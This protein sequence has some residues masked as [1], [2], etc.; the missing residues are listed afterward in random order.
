MK[1][2]QFI[3]QADYEKAVL[4]NIERSKAIEELNKLILAKMT[5]VTMQRGDTFV[6]I[7]EG[8]EFDV[9]GYVFKVPEPCDHIVSA[10]YDDHVKERRQVFKIIEGY[11]N[12]CGDEVE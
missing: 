2:P 12:R 3:T 4:Q 7:K 9:M 1:T 5:P 6:T 11:C 10:V 8:E